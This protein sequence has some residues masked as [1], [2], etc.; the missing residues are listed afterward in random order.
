MDIGEAVLLDEVVG[1][2]FHIV[3]IAGIDEYAV[4]KFKAVMDIS[5]NGHG[6]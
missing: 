3:G 4:G 2:I 1:H 6:N 5:E